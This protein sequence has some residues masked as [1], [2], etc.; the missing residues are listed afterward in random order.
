M[1][2]IEPGGVL[3]CLH[4]VYFFD[5]PEWVEVPDFFLSTDASCGLGY[6]AFLNSQ[7]FNGK[8]YPAQLSLG[9][10]YKELSLLHVMHGVISYA[11]AAFS[12]VAM[13]GVW[14]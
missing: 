11:I 10:F 14:R 6:G 13:T 1:E 5:L 3:C 8:W 7:W 2:S 9:I 4:D 12:F